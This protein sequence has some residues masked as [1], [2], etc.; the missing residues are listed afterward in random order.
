[1][2]SSWATICEDLLIAGI[3]RRGVLATSM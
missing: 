3:P 2:I 1:M